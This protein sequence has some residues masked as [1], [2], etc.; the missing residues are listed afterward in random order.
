MFGEM[1]TIYYFCA[2]CHIDL[3]S[4]PSQTIREI[5]M[6]ANGSI[7]CICEVYE[8]NDGFV[9]G[10]NSATAVSKRMAS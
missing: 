4:T 2:R 10:I 9:V 5:R 7:E 1:C 8:I 6:N 3:E